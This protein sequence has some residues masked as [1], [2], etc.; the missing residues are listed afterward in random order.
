MRTNLWFEDVIDHYL[1]ALAEGR[2]W[3]EAI[4]AAQV[5]VNASDT[6]RR[7]LTQKALKAKG[8]PYS[9]QHLSDLV[10]KGIFPAPFRLPT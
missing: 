3:R 10:N 6:P 2:D 9:R 7:V 1:A 4:A 5:Q 8:I